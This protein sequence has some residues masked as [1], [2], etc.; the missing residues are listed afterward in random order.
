MSWKI[1][2]H[3][4]GNGQQEIQV[5]IIVKEMK[6][7]WSTNSESWISNFKDRLK[8]VPRKNIFSAELGYKATP[9]NLCSL[10]VWKMKAN[11]DLNY[12]MF[13]VTYIKDD[14]N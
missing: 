3:K 1:E 9:I 4:R 13:T 5:A 8:E 10:E 7:H 12:K 11:G 6:D 14:N 2:Q